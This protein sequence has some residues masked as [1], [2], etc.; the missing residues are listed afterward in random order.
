[1]LWKN[2]NKKYGREFLE[3]AGLK[4]YTTLDMNLQ[5]GAE[6]VVQKEAERNV[7]L[8]A[9]NAALVAIDA[10]EGEVLAMVGSRDYFNKTIDGQVNIATS[11]RQPGSSFKPLVYAKAFEKGFQPETILLIS[12]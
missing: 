5:V 11:A 12:D 6:E 10:Q 7:A 9:T 3:Q 8:G 1:M 4:I 2:S